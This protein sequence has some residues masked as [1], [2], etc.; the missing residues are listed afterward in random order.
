MTRE[1]GLVSTSIWNSR[2]FCGLK[3]DDARLLYF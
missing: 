1:F 3:S 2:K